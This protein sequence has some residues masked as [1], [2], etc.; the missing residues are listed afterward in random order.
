M[1][2]IDYSS[3]EI[4]LIIINSTLAQWDAPKVQ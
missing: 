4:K 1:E 3:S 2:I